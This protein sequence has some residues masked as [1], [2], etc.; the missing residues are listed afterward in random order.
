MY[1]FIGSKIAIKINLLYN[2]RNIEIELP[3]TYKEFLN[4]LENKLYLTPEILDSS[5]IYYFDKE[6]DKNIITEENYDESKEENNGNFEMEI[7]FTSKNPK[8]DNDEEDN[9]DENNNINKKLNKKELKEIEK[10]IAKKYAKIFEEKI[11]KKDLEHK[12]EIS[13]IKE[14]L[15]K[16]INSLIE[17]NGNQFSALSEYYN[18]KMKEEFQKYNEMIIDNLNK[19]ISQSNLNELMQEIINNKTENLGQQYFEDNDEDEL[20]SGIFSTII[21]K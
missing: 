15:E 7:D 3:S 12:K 10:K 19:G 1:Y 9:N 16:I 5:M 18:N 2:K 14:N 21:K 8:N 11:R 20:N 13:N 6:G 4:L 17:N